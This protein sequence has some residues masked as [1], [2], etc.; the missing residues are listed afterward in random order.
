MSHNW[1]IIQE[2]YAQDCVFMVEMH[3]ALNG[4]TMSLQDNPARLFE[5]LSGIQNQYSTATFQISDKDLITTI[6]KKAPWEYSLVLTSRMRAKDAAL[7]ILDLHEAMN[8]LWRTMYAKSNNAGKELSLA[9]A[10]TK[11]GPVACYRCGKSGHKAFE[12]CKPKNNKK[13]GHF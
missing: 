3:Q 6:L 2:I 5:T 13:K 9:S 12:F 8:Q 11:K 7:T 4:V 10:D 1:R